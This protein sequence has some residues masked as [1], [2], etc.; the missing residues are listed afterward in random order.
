MT[1]SGLW[2]NVTAF[3]VAG[4]S[5]HLWRAPVLAKHAVATFSPTA[6]KQRWSSRTKDHLSI[7]KRSNAGH[8]GA[9]MSDTSV[10]WS[11]PYPA[12][13]VIQTKRQNMAI[14]HF[15]PVQ[16]QVLMCCWLSEYTPLK[17]ATVQNAQLCKQHSN[18]CA[19]MQQTD[20]LAGLQ[21]VGAI[22]CT[23]L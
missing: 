5:C 3:T 21:M 17:C 2:R 9:S 12:M 10:L 23:K 1:S 8:C 15:F 18:V 11:N 14:R 6:A 20:L 19:C 7:Q 13:L 22:S 4:Y 16:Y